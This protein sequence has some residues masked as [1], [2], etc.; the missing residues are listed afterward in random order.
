MPEEKGVCRQVAPPVPDEDPDDADAQA[1]VVQLDREAI[2]GVEDR[3]IE[4]VRVPEWNGIVYVR[5]LNGVERDAWEDA[6]TKARE[7]G[8]IKGVLARLVV[9]AAC[10]EQGGALFTRADVDALNRKNCKAL[11]RIFTKA[12]QLSGITESDIEDLA[13]NSESDLSDDS[14]SD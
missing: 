12:R 9:L 10:N 2:L 6:I 5:S 8:G 7:K 4:P 1:P 3:V 13:G 11:G 14:G